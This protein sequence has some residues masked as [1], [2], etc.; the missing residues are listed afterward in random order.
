MLMEVTFSLP[1]WHL[2]IKIS[3]TQIRGQRQWYVLYLITLN[4]TYNA[5]GQKIMKAKEIA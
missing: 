4:T 5:Q 2:F 1:S 3:F